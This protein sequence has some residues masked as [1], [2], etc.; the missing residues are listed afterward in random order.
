MKARPAVMTWRT[1]SSLESEVC[2]GV[3]GQDMDWVLGWGKGWRSRWGKD[4]GP[5]P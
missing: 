5:R 3:G 1:R 4:L 2:V